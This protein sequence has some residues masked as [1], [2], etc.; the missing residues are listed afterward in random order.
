MQAM[1]MILQIWFYQNL[2]NKGHTCVGIQRVF[3]S[4]VVDFHTP[5]QC[6]PLMG[7]LRAEEEYVLKGEK[8]R[9]EYEM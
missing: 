9:R 2:I 8:Q 5:L 7:K 6:S 1:H 3:I 4:T